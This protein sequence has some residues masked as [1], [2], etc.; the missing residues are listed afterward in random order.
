MMRST[1]KKNKGGE[2]GLT[3]LGTKTDCPMKITV[4][5]I[6]HLINHTP[7]IKTS[8]YS[9]DKHHSYIIMFIYTSQ[10]LKY[11]VKYHYRRT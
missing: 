10:N 4:T 7:I 2:E 6:Q 9:T 3:T 1:L 5:I 11:H 8:L